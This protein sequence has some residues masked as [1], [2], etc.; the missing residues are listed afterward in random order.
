MNNFFK[1][2]IEIFNNLKSTPRGKAVFFF[3]FYLIFFIVIF[4]LAAAGGK[5]TNKYE[6]NNKYD[7]DLSMIE[8][9]NYNF[10][11]INT[12]DV[13]SIEFSGKRYK[14]NSLYKNNNLLYFKNKNKNYLNNN[15]LWVECNEPNQFNY[16]T[17]I[18]NIKNILNKS[19]YMSKTDYESGKITYNYEISTTTLV[20]LI[21]DIDIDLDDKTNSITLSTDEEKH[22][23]KI[24]FNLDSYGIYNKI[25][26][27][28][29]SI[30]LEY[31]KFG[32]IEKIE[33]PIK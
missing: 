16:F 9:N 20:K 19:T 5:D 4:S 6:N 12:I 15:D 7:Y 11:Y 21:N 27:L 25:C 28:K 31:D 23:N 14:D 13:D 29:F 33:S 10:K 18:N 1:K 22:I 24:S 32:E 8:K 17:D 2:T 26:K 30:D 3:G